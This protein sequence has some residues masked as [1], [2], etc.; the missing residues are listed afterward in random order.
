MTQVVDEWVNRSGMAIDMMAHFDF[1]DALNLNY[2]LD[3]LRELAIGMAEHF[4]DP[5]EALYADQQPLVEGVVAY[6]G[7][8]LV[9]L[10]RGYWDWDDVPDVAERGQPALADPDLITRLDTHRWRFDDLEAPGVPIVC[11]HAALDLA[12][13]SP[14]HLLLAQLTRLSAEPGPIVPTAERWQAKV[15]A[16]SVAHPE[17]IAVTVPTLTDG[18]PI[19]PPSPLLDGWLARQRRDFPDWAS[20]Y[21]GTYDYSPDTLNALGELIF[22]H[23]PSEAAFEDPA[24]AHFAEGATWDVGEMMCRADPARWMYRAHQRGPDDPLL[25]CFTIQTNDNGDFTTP[26]W[27]ILNM[28][29]YGDPGRLRSGYDAWEEIAQ[30]NP[31]ANDRA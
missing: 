25:V 14:L 20:T 6:V 2:S 23:T 27:R 29:K 11:A 3:S 28:L 8:C 30:D 22:R 7:E 26:F 16:H 1:G 5:A 21:G 19:M 24:N 9:R 18:M 31:S 15:H 12:P 4:A 10:A 13:I 17:W